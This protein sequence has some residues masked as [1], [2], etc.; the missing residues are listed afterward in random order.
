MGRVLVDSNVLI[1][2]GTRNAEWG[3]W[4]RDAL[5]RTAESHTLVINPIIYSEISVGYA[6]IEEV[7][8]ALPPAV[9]QREALPWT[10]G[11]LAGRCFTAYRRRGGARR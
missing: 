4:S 8:A 6:R 10:A 11:F 5:E 1:D 7:D 2:I 9:F 3:A